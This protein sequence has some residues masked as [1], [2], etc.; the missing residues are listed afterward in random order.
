MQARAWRD[1]GYKTESVDVSAEKLAFVSDAGLSRNSRG[2]PKQDTTPLLG[3]TKATTFVKPG[4]D[5]S[6]TA[7]DWGRFEDE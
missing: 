4:V 1:S 7:P 6:Q 2:T 5:L 3:C